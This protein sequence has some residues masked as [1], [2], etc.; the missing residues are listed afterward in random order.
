MAIVIGFHTGTYDLN[1]PEGS[2]IKYVDF[3]SLYPFINKEV[4]LGGTVQ[5]LWQQHGGSHKTEVAEVVTAN[6]KSIHHHGR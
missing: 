6:S 5:P 4:S 2:K 3:T 1:V